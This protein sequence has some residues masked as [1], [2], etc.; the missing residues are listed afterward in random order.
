M[1]AGEQV[2][3]FLKSRFVLKIIRALKKAAIF[4]KGKG[5]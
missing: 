3:R 5:N 1:G 2:Q 4:L